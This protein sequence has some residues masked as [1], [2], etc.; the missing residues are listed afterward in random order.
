MVNGTRVV[1]TGTGAITSLGHTTRETWEAVKAGRSG[2]RRV[3]T[4]DPSAMPSKV[5]SEVVDFK[6]EARLDR[7]EARR[8]SRFVQFAMV[9]TREALEGSGLQVTEANRD[10]VGVI[11]GSAIGGLEMI[12]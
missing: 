7:K 4:F 11:V 9:A 10:Q 6:P 8:M 3:Q 12:E 5:A 2:I 1:V